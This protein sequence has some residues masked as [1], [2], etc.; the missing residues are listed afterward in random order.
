MASRAL[1]GSAIAVLMGAV[2]GCG[3]TETPEEDKQAVPHHSYVSRPDLAPPV[4]DV[5]E[6]SDEASDGYTFLTPNFDTEQPSDGALILDAAGEPVWMETAEDDD[7]DDDIFDLRVQEY[8]G[9]PVLTYFLGSS[10]EGRG[11]GEIVMLDESYE[12]VARVTTT[13]DVGA[14]N[15]DF[16]DTVITEEGTMLLGAYVPKQHDLSEVGGP[17]DGWVE[18]AVIQEI[19]IETGEVLFEWSA[20]EHIPLSETMFDYGDEAKSAEEDAEENEDAPAFPSEEYPYDYFHINSITEDDDGNLLVSARHTHTVYKLNRD[21]GEVEWKLGGA[22][23]D[24]EMGEGATFSWQ[25]DA[26]RSPDGTITLLDNHSHDPG[27]KESSRGLRLEVDEEAMT[28]SVHTEYLPPE[29]RVGF[30]MANLQELEDGTV[31]IGWG[32]APLFS[33][34]TNEGELLRD[35]CHGS[36]CYGEDYKGNG[37]SYRSYTFEWEGRPAT[38]PDVVVQDDDGARTAYVSWN[39][40]TEV[41]Q[42]RLVTGEDEASA[43]AGEVV[44]RESFETSLTVPDEAQ[45]VAVEALDENGEVLGT[46][47]AEEAAAQQ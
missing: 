10:R 21:T 37:T 12:E 9:E 32:M 3:A 46:G 6:D 2:A 26:K 24:F 8:Q 5:R 30:A 1:A 28:A 38:S 18:D 15:A 7:L 43:T 4:V 47:V 36:D 27:A 31:H 40:A 44:D 23:S 34:Y 33:E 16:H 29:E 11:N 39:G 41:A 22:D 35:V 42:W 13:A 19:D 25:H 17:T 45:Y 14:G 20:I